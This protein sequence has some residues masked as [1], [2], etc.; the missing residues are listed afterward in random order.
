MNPKNIRPV[1][2]LI[3]F[4]I[5]M[6]WPAVCW[7]RAEDRKL[8]A[9]TDAM[10]VVGLILILTGILYIAVRHGD[11]DVTEYN[12]MRYRARKQPVI[13]SFEAFKADRE[14]EREGSFNYPLLM[15]IL[16]LIISFVIA[17][18]I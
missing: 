14:A 9:V 6:I 8:L 5:A 12:L 11:F 2:L 1:K 10:T 16:M 17:L 18:L 3:T 15:G 7:L 13:K 4:L